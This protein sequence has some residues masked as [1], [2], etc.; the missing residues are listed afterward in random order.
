MWKNIIDSDRPPMKLS[1]MRIACWIPK[2]TNTHSHYVI[3]TAF[4]LQ[5]LLKEGFSKLRYT[6]I[7]RLVK[8]SYQNRSSALKSSAIGYFRC[9]MKAPDL[10][11]SYNCEWS[12]CS[13]C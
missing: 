4:P 10:F 8:N 9:T 7:A 5:Q 3:L 12:S 6:Y 11:T 2:A 1:P 13:C